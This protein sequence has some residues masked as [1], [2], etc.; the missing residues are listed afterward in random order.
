MEIIKKFLAISRRLSNSL[1]L[2]LIVSG[3]AAQQSVIK[4]AC[5]GNSVTEGLGLKNPASYSYPA[6]LQQ[7]LGSDYNVVNFGHSGATLL[8]K[9]HNPYYKTGKFEKVLAFK[10]D[11]AI[12]HLGLND[13]DPR[14]WPD[15][16]DEFAAD[17]AW[18]IDTLR[19]ASPGVKIFICKLSPIFSDHP[20]FKS[21][22]RD[23]Y[24]QIQAAVDRI[25]AANGVDL[26]DFSEPLHA[27]PD[28]VPDALHPNEV[29]AAILAKTVYKKITGNYGGLQLSPVF[30][31][32]MVLQR[33]QPVRFYGVANKNQNVS[34][35]FKGIMQTVVADGNGKWQTRFAAQPAGGPFQAIIS[36][37]DTIIKLDDI[38]IGEVWLCSG[39]SNMAFPL[40][41][42]INMGNEMEDAQNNKMLRLLNRKVLAET[43]NSAWDSATLAKI[44]KLECFSG[45]WQ[46]CDSSKAKSFSAVAYYFGK[47]IQQQL[48]VPVGVI[49]VAVGGSP[50]ESWIDRYTM[51]HHSVLVNELSNWRK[52]DFLQPWVRER[53]DTNLK[54]TNLSKQ[55]HPFEPCYNFE[56]GIQ[57]LTGFLIAGAIWY[58]GESNAHNS[59]LYEIV[60]PEL[61]KSWRRQWGFEFPFYYVQ[62]SSINRPSWPTF[63]YSQFQLLQK[64]PN[65]GMAVSSDLGEPENVHPREKKTVAERLARLALHF[66]YGQ[67]VTPYGPRFRKVQ[68]K[69]NQVIISFQYADKLRTSD[70]K[71]LRGFKLVNTKGIQYV[72]NAFIRGETVVIPIDQVKDAVSV[73]YSWDPFSDANL[74]NGDYL[75]AS[76][77]KTPVR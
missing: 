40:R 19:K 2:L 41:A 5:I 22:T 60:F 7:E 48:G 75:P 50:A 73:L 13:T 30:G 24:W 9:G 37:A 74:V 15:Y 14:N 38:L 44:N 6:V 35:I 52:S 66:T 10:A 18:L 57:P 47:K 55:R 77:F 26:I 64:I 8:R 27:R 33:N 62:L 34:V 4:V 20:R 63:R 17:Y 76:T 1:L 51:E 71:A 70:G 67:K 58:Q 11:I 25:A 53:A 23:W 42:A 46:T 39:Q 43:N 72:A 29:G 16:R 54:M 36:S 69:D 3:G 28:L 12:I 32:H 65:S 45:A 56:A 68:L 59:E 31:S 21:G 49:Q 61:V